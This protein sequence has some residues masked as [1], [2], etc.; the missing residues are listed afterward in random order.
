MLGVL[1]AGSAAQAGELEGRVIGVKD[2]DS[3]ET[4]VDEQPI[5][6]RIYGIDTPERA[7]PW[8][9]RAKKAT[10]ALVFG[11]IVRIVERDLDR[12]DRTVAEIFVGE[13]CVACALVRD[14]HAWV[15]RKYT[16]DPHL[17]A[18]EARAREER[19]GLW[20]LPESERVPPWDWRRG[21][22]NASEERPPQPSNTCGVKR[23]CREMSSCDEAYFHLDT[24]G[25]SRLDGDGDGVPC[26]KICRGS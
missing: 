22:R 1:L 18:L 16:D 17:L 5:E 15:Y 9:A 10:S 14:G 4:L 20:G 23:Y 2:G 7:Q 13:V 21:K 3:I 8:S 25:L 24:C 12:Y 26:E 19:V 11:K 6:I